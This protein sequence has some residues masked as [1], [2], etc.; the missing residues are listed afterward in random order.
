MLFICVEVDIFC[1]LIRVI[2]LGLGLCYRE[3]LFS[4]VPIFNTTV[5]QI[6]PKMP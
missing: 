3:F 5:F 4:I 1:W 2:V 6:C